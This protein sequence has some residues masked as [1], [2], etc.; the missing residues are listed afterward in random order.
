LLRAGGRRQAQKRARRHSAGQQL[1][2]AILGRPPRRHAVLDR[3]SRATTRDPG[4]PVMSAAL[5]L[6]RLLLAP[7]AAAVLLAV[8]QAPPA[9][10]A[11]APLPVTYNFL[12][13]IAAALAYPNASPPGAN[14]WSCRPSAPHPDPVVLVNGTGEDMADGFSALSPLLVNNGYC[15]F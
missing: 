12:A 15:V 4:R 6:G 14:N 3:S 2:R 11:S 8:A 7:V 5:R 13:G 1:C 10:P 9:A